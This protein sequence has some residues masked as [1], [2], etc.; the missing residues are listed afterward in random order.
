MGLEFCTIASGSSGNSLY[1][2]TEHTRILIDAGVSGK[3]I[4]EGLGTVGVVGNQV[5]ALFITHEHLDHV[6]GAGV[7]S[8]RFDVPVYATM[9]TWDA[10]EDTLG[11]IAPR[12]RRY[13]Y[14]GEPCVINDMCINPFS[15]PHDAANP[16]GYG[17]TVGDKKV[18]VATDIGHVT[19]ALRENLTDSDI[20]LLEANHDEELLKKGS[21]PWRLKQRILGEKG[22]LSNKTAGALLSEIM[23]GRLKHVFLG[24]LSEENNRPHLAYETVADILENNHI[25][26]GGS[27]KMDMAARYSN[28]VK[29]TI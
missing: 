26:L 29:V 15:I 16:V 2:G 1:I 6:K 8:R 24:H 17:V 23:S 11:K 10:M 9:E 7:F 28:G 13:V 4:T 20:L 12:N 18:T 3:R 5:D 14:E 22:H 21:Y 27:L 25:K 19:D